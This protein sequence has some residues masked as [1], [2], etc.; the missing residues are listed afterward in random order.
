MTEQELFN[1]IKDTEE[2]KALLDLA[3]KEEKNLQKDLWQEKVASTFIS[4][5][6]E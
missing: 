4:A 2:F 6:L 3:N 5:S 1:K